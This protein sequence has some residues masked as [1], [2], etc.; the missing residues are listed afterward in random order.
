MTQ[1]LAAKRHCRDIRNKQIVTQ[2]QRYADHGRLVESKS[3]TIGGF[4]LGSAILEPSKTKLL[5]ERC[6]W[7]S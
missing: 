2:V 7:L 1:C 4:W 5:I 3:A 6:K